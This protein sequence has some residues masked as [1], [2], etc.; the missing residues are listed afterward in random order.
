MS[1]DRN[2]LLFY[3]LIMNCQKEKKP[4]LNGMKEYLGINLATEMKDL[5][6]KNYKTLVKEIWRWYKKKWKDIVCS[7]V[8]QI[9]T[10]KMATWPKTIYQ[11]NAISIIISVTFS[12]LLKQITLK[13]TQK[14]K[15][16]QIARLLCVACRSV[17][18]QPGITP[19][20]LIPGTQNLNHWM[21]RELLPNQP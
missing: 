16:C 3:T 15:F 5:H 12:T 18:L 13:F 11:F 17:V 7:W 1:K 6:C 19:L 20:P 10:V 21:V 8:G 4:I 9:N 14:H 2:L